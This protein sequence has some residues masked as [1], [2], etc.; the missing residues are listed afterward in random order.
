MR[1]RVE[2]GQ[3]IPD[4]IEEAGWESFRFQE[5]DLLKKV[6]QEK[7]TG[8]VFACGG[9]IVE[10]LEA[11]EMLIKYQESD[12]LVILVERSIE[13]VLAYLQ[14]DKS[15]PAYVDDMRD[16]WLRRKD[17][18]MECSNY[19]LYNLN[20]PTA[21]ISKDSKDF[22][23]FV[24]T[25]TGQRPVDNVIA[26]DHSFFVSLTMSD[27]ATALDSLP[28]IVV[29]SDAVE[30]RVDLLEDQAN[31]KSLPSPEYV[32]HQLAMLRSSITEPIIY[33]V[34]SQS[35]G[36]KFPDNAHDEASTL[37]KLGLRMGRSCLGSW[38]FLVFH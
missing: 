27:I 5:K 18:Y 2:T 34:R 12:G 23:R 31:P 3:T 33:T 30:L 15:R 4:I 9:G 24:R 36:G 7:P 14:L 32:A 17:W 25:I 10:T 29:G 8:H 11:R 38:R 35:Q 21:S 37:Y 22:E 6:I 19:Q 16:V 26:K 28:A 13:D 20:A 1:N